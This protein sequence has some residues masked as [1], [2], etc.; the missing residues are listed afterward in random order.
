MTNPIYGPGFRRMAA[1]LG[2]D[3]MEE[4]RQDVLRRQAA[5]LAEVAAVPAA[6]SRMR[7]RS[8]DYPAPRGRGGR[9]RD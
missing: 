5:A 1:R 9:R 6:E 7:D 8:T 3:K 2:P 4:M